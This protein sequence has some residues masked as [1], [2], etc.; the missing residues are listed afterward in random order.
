MVRF[1]ELLVAL[2][3]LVLVLSNWIFSLNV[4]FELVALVLA[5]L[6]F[7]TG[8]HYLRDDRVIR[9]T[10][11]LVVSSMMAFIFR[12]FYTYYIGR[13]KNGPMHLMLTRSG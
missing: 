4:S 2:A 5:L 11:I 3:A 1:L 13:G 7:F 10:I 6:Y 8:I 9:G 12:K